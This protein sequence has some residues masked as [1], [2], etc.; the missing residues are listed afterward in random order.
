MHRSLANVVPFTVSAPSLI[1][2]LLMQVSADVG[3]R[4][5]SIA[6]DFKSVP[7]LK[8]RLTRLVDCGM[9]LPRMDN[10]DKVLQN[11]VMGC[12]ARVW[13]VVTQNDDGTV[14]IQADSDSEISRGLAAILLRVFD[15]C[16]ISEIESFDIQSL[17][18]MHVGPA[19]ASPS[20]TNSF[21]NMFSTLKKRANALAGQL[22]QFPSLVI[23]EDSL[24]PQGAFAEAQAQYLQPDTATVDRLAT[25]L[26]EKQIGIVA[27]FYMDPEV[28]GVLTSAKE[29]WPHIHISGAAAP[30][31][32]PILLLCMSAA[33]RHVPQRRYS[34]HQML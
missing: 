33:P 10:A 4:V 1:G 25:V 32:M 31:P 14:H 30:S 7:G 18:D 11:Q 2:R 27:H 23:T 12:A 20:R 26:R 6:S 21:H 15:G 13:M 9:A 16:H 34:R 17:E 22:P 28:Q 5:D 8:E 19:L 3:A 29:A 24:I